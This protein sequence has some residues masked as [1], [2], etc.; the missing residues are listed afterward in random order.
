MNDV[1]IV[2]NGPSLLESE[3]GRKIDRYNTVIRINNYELNGYAK[4]TGRKTDIWAM[5]TVVFGWRENFKDRWATIPEIWIIPSF[6]YDKDYQPLI[7]AA[8]IMHNNVHFSSKKL[9]AKLMIKVRAFPSTG[10]GVIT[11]ALLRYKSIDIIGFDHFVNEL[12]NYWDT[13]KFP[14]IPHPT[15]RERQY[16]ETLIKQNKV[17]RI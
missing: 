5:D 12:A 10:L 11:F 2:G 9:A 16:V 8:N 4:H 15:A 6:H 14:H 7:D 3:T 13:L 1:L 17:R